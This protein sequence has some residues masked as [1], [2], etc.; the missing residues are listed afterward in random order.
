MSST[1]EK[2]FHILLISSAEPHSC[3]DNKLESG[4]WK[5]P[6]DI[7]DADLT[8]DGKPLNLLHEEN[9]SRW[10]IEHHIYEQRKVEREDSIGR[11]RAKK[12]EDRRECRAQITRTSRM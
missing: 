2:Q 8:L 4:F 5:M 9:K 10:M 11:G 1:S 7:D 3:S 12:V 6:V